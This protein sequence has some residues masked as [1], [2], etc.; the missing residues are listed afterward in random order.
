MAYVSCPVLH[1]RVQHCAGSLSKHKNFPSR[2]A[3]NTIAPL[4]KNAVLRVTMSTGEDALTERVRNELAAEGIDFNNLLNASKVVS[5]TVKLDRLEAQTAE[6]AVDS[7]ER[8]AI[9]ANMA[10]VEKMLAKEKRQVMQTWLKR[11]F[12]AQAIVFIAIGGVLSN[13][14]LPGNFE[15]P[16]VG[17]ALGF[18]M[19]WL[20]TIPALR[21]RKGTS[22]AE[23]SALNVAFLAT[24]LVNVALPTVTK[25]CGQIWAADVVILVGCYLYYGLVTPMQNK[26]DGNEIEKETGKV[27]GLLKFLDWGSWR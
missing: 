20:F 26:P 11:L 24:P 19:T 5:L 9:E 21:A 1:S 17:Q 7:D 22:K 27:T 16:L 23:K 3:S 10:E 2:W 8:K 18:W 6:L 15:V 12:L 4:Q 13:N 25:N 14:L